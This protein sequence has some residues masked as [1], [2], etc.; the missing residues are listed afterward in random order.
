MQARKPKSPLALRKKSA[1]T[2]TAG[3]Q[4][5]AKPL[6]TGRKSAARVNELVVNATTAKN[7]FGAILKQVQAGRPVV[8]ENHGQPSAV[9]LSKADYD[10][11]VSPQD[12]HA[13][14]TLAAYRQEFEVF[15]A[16]MQTGES[17]KGIDAFLNASA[18]EIN[19]KIRTAAKRG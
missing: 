19:R 10:A 9:L 14:Q 3:Y 5:T 4:M 8:I 17:R 7:R 15:Y 2:V 16:G 13:Q 12:G 6:R 11:M 18:D 1:A